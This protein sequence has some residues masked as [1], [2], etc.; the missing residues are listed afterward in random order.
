MYLLEQASDSP[1]PI[2]GILK[3]LSIITFGLLFGFVAFAFS[4]TSR[5]DY[6]GA[7]TAVI[8]LVL[9]VIIFGLC[10]WRGVIAIIHRKRKKVS[11]STFIIWILLNLTAM[12][13]L[14]WLL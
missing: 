7:A 12:F 13:W 9:F 1:T 3:G 4:L 14:F 6:T 5:P 8:G 10:T 2:L 11:I